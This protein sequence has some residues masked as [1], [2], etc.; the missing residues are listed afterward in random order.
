MR[1]VI[2]GG[3]FGGLTTAY[4]L[5]KHLSHR[6]CEITLLSRDGRFVFIPSLPWVAL[7]SRTLD[8]ISIDLEKPLARRSVGFVPRA[9]QR[10]DPQAHKVMT[11]HEE[12]S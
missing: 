7:G 9:V 11:D 12:Y 10:I 8:Q 3:S 6:D 2:I 1:V 5:R 4:E